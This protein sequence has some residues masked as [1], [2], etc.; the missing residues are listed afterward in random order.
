MKAFQ[1]TM[2]TSYKL[3]IS[4]SIELSAATIDDYKDLILACI[5]NGNSSISE[6]FA[7]K[8]LDK[9]K[10]VDWKVCNDCIVSL[11]ASADTPK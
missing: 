5:R 10:L 6:I 2:L 11:Y 1:Y 8:I 4:L 7:E 9:R 3:Y